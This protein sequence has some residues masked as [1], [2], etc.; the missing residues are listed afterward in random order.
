[1]KSSTDSEAS[2]PSTQPTNIESVVRALRRL[3][4]GDE[5]EQRETFEYLKNALE[6]DRPSSR[7]SSLLQTGGRLRKLT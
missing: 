7:G 5:Q 2:E 1:M 3:L 4:E 6:E